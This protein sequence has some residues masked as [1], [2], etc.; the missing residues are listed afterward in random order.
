MNKKII[1]IRII[2]NIHMESKSDIISNLTTISLLGGPVRQKFSPKVNVT[3]VECELNHNLTYCPRCNVSFC[4]FHIM[5]HFNYKTC[6]SC[7][8]DTCLGMMGILPNKSADRCFRCET[9]NT[10]TR[11]K[12]VSDELYDQSLEKGSLSEEIKEINNTVNSM[13]NSLHYGSP[14]VGKF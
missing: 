5:P 13:Y 7:D 14:F 3:C 11:L 12:S 8:K 10:L 4:N 1:S 6:I 9:S 2:E